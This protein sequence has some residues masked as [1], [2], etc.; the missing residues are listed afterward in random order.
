MK[1][2]KTLLL[3]ICICSV[4]KINAQPPPGIHWSADG[5]SYYENSSEGIV[6]YEM[7]SFTK[8]VVAT[9]QQLTPKDSS[10]SLKVRNFF[11]SDDGKKILIYTNSKKVW[12]YDTRG[13]YWV[14]NT[15][16]NSLRQ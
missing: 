16:D 4:I 9:T 11:F 10:Q 8:T 12:R 15:A 2:L 1:I 7:P 13:D 6:K 3:F 14:L 5:N